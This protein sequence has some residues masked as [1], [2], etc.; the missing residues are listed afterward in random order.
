[1]LIEQQDKNTIHVLYTEPFASLIIIISR[2]LIQGIL[3]FPY[4][5]RSN[6]TQIDKT[7]DETEMGP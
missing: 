5:V 4:D 1:M 3:L 7:Q 6:M 2:A